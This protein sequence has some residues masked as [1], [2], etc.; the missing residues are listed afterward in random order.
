VKLENHSI[1]LSLI[2]H[3]HQRPKPNILLIHLLTVTVINKLTRLFLCKPLASFQTSS[4]VLINDLNQPYFFVHKQLSCEALTS[5]GQS[6]TE[7]GTQSFKAIKDFQI[8]QSNNND[9]FKTE[10]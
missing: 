1:P 2:H 8:N 6:T 9:D 4:V 10:Q 7:R 3:G 5:H